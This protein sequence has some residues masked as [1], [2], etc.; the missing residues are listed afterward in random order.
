[1]PGLDPRHPFRHAPRLAEP[2]RN[3]LQG[4]ARTSPAMT[5]GEGGSR[6]L[7]AKTHALAQ[8][9]PKFGLPAQPFR[10]QLRSVQSSTCACL[11]PSSSPP[12][13]PP[14]SAPAGPRELGGRA[15]RSAGRDRLFPR[16]GRR[17]A[18]QRLH[19]LGRR[20]RCS[21]GFG[22]RVVHVKV[23][24]TAEVGLARADREGGRPRRR[25][26][27]RP[28]LDQRRE[29]RRDEARGAAAAVSLGDEAAELPLRRR[30]EQADGRERFHRAGRRAGSALGHGEARLLPRHRACCPSRRSRPRRSANGSRRIPA[31]SP[32]R[33][34]RILPA[35][36]S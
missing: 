11:P 15:R 7:R 9:S 17:A 23:S 24:D 8:I 6:D 14:R 18:H 30:R 3:G 10:C 5:T 31:A 2:S 12:S 21:S 19:R 22:V 27:G 29:F 13:S 4:Q 1:M 36:L 20:R 33:S 16:L 35:R 32:I 28:R 25:R 26:R 34:R